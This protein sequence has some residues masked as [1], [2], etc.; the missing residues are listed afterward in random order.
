MTKT[1]VN[2]CWYTGLASKWMTYFCIS[3][4][5]GWS[6]GSWGW[7]LWISKSLWEWKKFL[8]TNYNACVNCCW[9]WTS[10][11]V[12]KN[13]LTRNWLFSF[14]DGSVMEQNN[15]CPNPDH[16][17]STKGSYWQEVKNLFDRAR[18]REC[19]WIIISAKED[20]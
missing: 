15:E 16:F 5:W 1:I 18:E 10:L 8:C 20:K 7:E 2:V 6:W 9:A 4:S 13:K 17:I 12:R 19:L 14:I 3:K 11:W